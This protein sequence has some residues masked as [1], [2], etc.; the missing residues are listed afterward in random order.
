MEK[1]AQSTVLLTEKVEE[2]LGLYRE[3]PHRARAPARNQNLLEVI[4]K[5]RND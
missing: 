1:V 3:R 5:A 2:L 4:K